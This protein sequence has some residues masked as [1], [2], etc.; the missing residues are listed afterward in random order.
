MNKRIAN[1][2]DFMSFPANC[3]KGTS[4]KYKVLKKCRS[5]IRFPLPVKKSQK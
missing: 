1:A 5:F 4:G 2:I 3:M